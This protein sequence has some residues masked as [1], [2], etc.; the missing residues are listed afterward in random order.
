VVW[1]VVAGAVGLAVGRALGEFGVCPVVKR[2]WTPSWVLF[3]GGWCLLILAVFHMLTAGIGYAGWTYPF[4]VIGANSILI[5][6]IAE[7]P[8]GGWLMTQLQKHLPVDL[9]ATLARKV[10]EW[11]E[12]GGQVEAIEGVLKG[13]VLLA[14][15][16]LFLWWLYRKKVFVRI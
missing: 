9:F 11:T 13:V 12:A 1:L 8:L 4:R 14:V 15:Y 2:I 5:Y 16:W 10:G 7:V 6:V 3:S